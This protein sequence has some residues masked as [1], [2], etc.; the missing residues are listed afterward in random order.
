MMT[1]MGMTQTMI[2]SLEQFR[3]CKKLAIMGGTFDPIHMGHLIIAEAVRDNMKMEAVLFVPSGTP[4]H[5]L[6]KCITGNDHRYKMTQLAM[7]KNPWFHVSA[8]EMLRRGNSYTIDTIQ[9]IK[10]VC[11]DT[12]IYFITGVDAIE[13]IDTWKEAKK[14]VHSC[15]FIVLNRP[16]YALQ[17]LKTAMKVL[18]AD[19]NKLYF[20]DAPLIDISS[21]D[22]RQRVRN[23]K[24]IRYLLPYEVE[25]YIYEKKLYQY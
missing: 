20:L 1:N 2:T 19:Y 5:K 22:I 7:Q 13:L 6:D 12:E 4:P 3:K 18:E 24:S 10:E 8:I 17:K 16:G 23:G 25:E 9:Q 15:K 14:L 11:A 21:S